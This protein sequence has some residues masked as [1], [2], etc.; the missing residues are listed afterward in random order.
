M[1]IP[2]ISFI[3]RNGIVSTLLVVAIGAVLL[4]IFMPKVDKQIGD[5]GQKAKDMI[6]GGNQTA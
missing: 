2:F 1:K 5:L 4:K 3:K 6:K